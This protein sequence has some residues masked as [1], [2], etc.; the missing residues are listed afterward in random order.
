M[1]RGFA[2]FYFT[3]TNS[4]HYT[5]TSCFLTLASIALEKG[6]WGKKSGFKRSG[7][8]GQEKGHQSCISTTR[9]GVGQPHASLI[10]IVII[11]II[12]SRQKGERGE[13]YGRELAIIPWKGRTRAFLYPVQRWNHSKSTFRKANKNS[14]SMKLQQH[15]A[16]ISNCFTVT[17]H[18]AELQTLH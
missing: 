16:S 6:S 2:F 11:I 4:S 5:G 15:L 1:V 9:Q 8:G 13:C 7:G 17:C 12:P 18:I 14:N 10:I 3:I